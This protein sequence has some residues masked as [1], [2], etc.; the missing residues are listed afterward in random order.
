MGTL[1]GSCYKYETKG[2]THPNT[3]AFQF[4]NC[5]LS[6]ILFSFVVGELF[7]LNAHLL[8][9]SKK[10]SCTNRITGIQV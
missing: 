3:S 4:L 5:A 2:T 7:E 9:R 6:K 1:N 10:R 8:L